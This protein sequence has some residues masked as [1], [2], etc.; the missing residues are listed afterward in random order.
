MDSSQNVNSKETTNHSPTQLIRFNLNQ[1]LTTLSLTLTFL[2]PLFY[3]TGINAYA[4]SLSSYGVDSSLFPLNV[5]DVYVQFYY[6][7]ILLFIEG[8]SLIAD[9]NLI[10]HISLVGLCIVSVL[11][12]VLYRIS[13][14]KESSIYK[15]LKNLINKIPSQ[16]IQINYYIKFIV[17]LL[18]TDRNI[19]AIVFALLIIIYLPS[20]AYQNANLQANITKKEFQS[21]NCEK[22]R[23]I[24]LK[25][26]NKNIVVQ[27]LAVAANKEMIAIYNGEKTTVLHFKQGYSLEYSP[28][29]EDS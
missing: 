26:E 2:L 4:G 22:I 8:A 16:K 23:C 10:L 6:A 25:D 12:F 29:K 17:T 27:G 28:T 5:Q 3:V 21:S 15:K 13:Q 14:N 20:H 18:N 19:M 24:A 7:C 9:N 11:I 1:L